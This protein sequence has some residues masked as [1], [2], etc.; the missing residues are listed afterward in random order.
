MEI[1]KDLN[2][3]IK[4]I[5]DKISE[6]IIMLEKLKEKHDNIE[7]EISEFCLH[8]INYIWLGWDDNYYYI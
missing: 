3:L 8:E 5:N 4:K 2:I 6:D 1:K 7:E